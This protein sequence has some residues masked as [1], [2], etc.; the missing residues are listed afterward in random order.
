MTTTAEHIA[1]IRKA[2]EAGPTPG[3]W[4][5][6]HLGQEGKCQCR[7]IVSEDYAGGIATV[8]LDNC[9][10]ISDG[11]ND[12][13]PLGEAVANMALIACCNPVAMTAVL[14]EIDRLQAENAALRQQLAEARGKAL[15]EAASIAGDPVVCLSCGVVTLSS[16]IGE[17]CDRPNI[18]SPT[19]QQ[20]AAAIRALKDSA[21]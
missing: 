7:S 14:A 4:N 13:P 21:S 10:P 20:L 15:D 16:H 5:E 19:H 3:E 11:G 9:K 18:S 12:C 1:A 2:L 8:H 17:C 6:G